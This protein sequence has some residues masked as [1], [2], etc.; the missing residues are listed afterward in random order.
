[1]SAYPVLH[2]KKIP[3]LLIAVLL[4]LPLKLFGLSGYVLAADSPQPIDGQV[5]A[6]ASP[7]TA[8]IANDAL[9][10]A[11]LGNLDR[12]NAAVAER[13]IKIA[14][15]GDS[16]AQG[17]ADGLYENSIVA[18]LMRLARQQNPDIT[19][20]FGNFSLAG[21][22]IATYSDPGYKGVAGPNDN[23][24]KGFY[25]QPGIEAT[26][27]WPGGS[28][29]GKSWADHVKDFG[30]DLVIY[31]FGANDLSGVSS[32]NAY[33]YLKSLDYQNT[34]LK[35]PSAAIATA[36]LPTLSFGYQEQVQVAADAARGVARARHITL[37]DIN[38]IFNI[39]RS[40]IDVD[41]LIY[42]PDDKIDG[43]PAGWDLEAGT[44]FALIGSP[45]QYSLIG[46]GAMM[47]NKESKDVNLSATFTLPKWSTQTGGIRYRSLG[48]GLVQYTA[49]VTDKQ[50][51]LYWGAII[52]GS[53]PVY[54][55]IPDGSAATLQVLVVGAKH[56]VYLNG[57]KVISL[58]D[59]NNLRFG[60]FGLVV[61]GG[62][63]TISNWAANIGAPKA[64][65]TPDLNDVQI[66]GVR[67]F[68][69][70]PS[71]PGGNAINH[72]TKTANALIWGTSLM[73]L[74]YHIRTQP[75]GGASASIQA[76]Q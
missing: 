66:Y 3:V 57:V 60:N 75:R 30:P 49:Q 51:L 35:V 22:G 12:L 58:Y 5:T 33:Y 15:V 48:S 11:N 23:P 29:E 54:L 55:S 17:D 28:V 10:L 50:V 32:L 63:G 14:V 69:T 19:F 76:T 74:L 37:L 16:I 70:N 47:R 64:L 21:R 62:E 65:G 36:A 72:P 39:H 7:D 25:R 24:E 40:A 31:A 43:Y 34:W 1:M 68:A 41:D 18:T 27:Q 52:I 46:Q 42:T 26:R 20:T 59:Y 13:S 2:R 56:E 38:R 8:P 61:S 9:M 44:K 4:S 6:T 45:A 71:G 73:P 67:D 53:S